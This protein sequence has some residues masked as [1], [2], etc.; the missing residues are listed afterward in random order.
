MAL[1]NEILAH[2]TTFAPDGET[3][4]SLLLSASAF[5]P[6][7]SVLQEIKDS[8]ITVIDSCVAGVRHKYSLVNGDLH[9]LNEM[10]I[11]DVLVLKGRYRHG[12]RYGTWKSWDREGNRS[13]KEFYVQGKRW[14]KFTRYDGGVISETG[15]R[16]QDDLTGIYN[17]YSEGALHTSSEYKNDKLNGLYQLWDRTGHLRSQKTYKNGVLHG[18]CYEYGKGKNALRLE[19]EYYKSS[20]YG[21]WTHWSKRGVRTQEGCYKDGQRIGTW[22]FWDERGRVSRKCYD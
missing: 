9:G 6:P 4:L 8:F 1:P 2:I 19:G 18:K 20:K 15:Y 22:K 3:L 12:E 5:H 10:F 13:M 7:S 17:T 11:D 16:F 14:G 21:I